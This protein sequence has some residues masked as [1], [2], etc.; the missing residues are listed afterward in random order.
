M[1]VQDGAG[2]D[3]DG[4]ASALRGIGRQQLVQIDLDMGRGD[5]LAGDLIGPEKRKAHDIDR[6]RAQRRAQCIKRLMAQPPHRDAGFMLDAVPRADALGF[7]VKQQLGDEQLCRELVSLVDIH[8]SAVDRSR[9][10][11]RDVR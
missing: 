8:G 5:G 6:L 1:G 4:H 3:G 11:K 9:H 2:V 10:L 7:L